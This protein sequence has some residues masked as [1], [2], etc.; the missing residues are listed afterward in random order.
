MTHPRLAIHYINLAHF[1]TH[2]AMLIFA[3]AVIVM[4]AEM[5]SD[6]TQLLPYAT[7]GFV[8][9][10]AGSLLAGWLG[11]TWSRR[12]MMQVFFI[13][14]GMSM[15]ATGLVRTPAQLGV[16]LGL[17]GLFASIYHPVGTA[18][19]VASAERL[20]RE[21]GINGVWGNV[22]VACSA[23]LT[24]ALAYFVGWRWAFIVPG[25]V[26]VLAGLGF[27]LQVRG[28]PPSVGA[29]ASTM[30]RVRRQ[31]MW[32]VLLALLASVVALSTAFNAI[33]LALPKIF[34][35]RLDGLAG[36]TALVSIIT[37][38]VFLCGALAQWLV[39]RM[40]DRHALKWVFLPLSVTLALLLYL[41]SDVAGWRLVPVAAVI[42]AAL[43]GQVTVND[44]M[45]G[46]YTS[47][48][49]RARAYAVR[50][51]VGF[52][53]AGASVSLVAWL[54]KLGG[55]SL[56]LRAL[57]ALCVLVVLAALA[58]PREASPLPREQP[59]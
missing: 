4:V 18:M 13:G 45:V 21:I 27:L 37:A 11:D 39:G 58:F 12:G 40:I 36:N 19:L 53:A 26:S 52:T 57:G 35:E 48:R 46:K 17:V 29:P 56:L 20:G 34:A 25:V 49:W 38:L 8:A 6:Y 31:D 50:Y 32:R 30:P 22:G 59:R 3:T 1:I 47:D 44:A 16:T 24:G 42:T 2:Y 51:F 28:E 54:H 10:G 33:T 43:F 5:G 23:L 15:I 9:F 41:A 7:P 14:I 55:F